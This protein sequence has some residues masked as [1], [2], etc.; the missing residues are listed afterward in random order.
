M[1]TL[2]SN[3]SLIKNS[4]TSKRTILCSDGHNSY[5]SFTKKQNIEHHIL[6]A[7]KG[8]KGKRWLSHS[9]Y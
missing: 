2:E 6:N 5:K 4:R 3:L 8:E 9:T 7:S 1:K